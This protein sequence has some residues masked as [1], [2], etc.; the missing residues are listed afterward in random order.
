MQLF[1]R[2]DDLTN[3]MLQLGKKGIELVDQY[4]DFVFLLTRQ[5]PGQV[6]A[7]GSQFP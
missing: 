5:T 3:E 7:T 1:D 6:T 2:H 4:P